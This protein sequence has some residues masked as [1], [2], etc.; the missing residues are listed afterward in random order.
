[1]C[2]VRGIANSPTTSVAVGRGLS[3]NLTTSSILTNKCIRST[4]QTNWT[5]STLPF[6][7]VWNGVAYGAGRFVA[8]CNGLYAATSVDGI[9]WTSLRM[10][11]TLNWTSITFGDGK[12]I[13]V[14][15][16]SSIA[17]FSMD[18]LNWS[19]INLPI[20]ATWTSVAYGNGRFVIPSSSVTVSLH[21]T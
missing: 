8:V 2:E 17:A 9:T 15:G 5:A 20:S 19:E 10:P 4:N 21:S 13:A 7:A 11:A 1:L 12:W 6:S 14:G 3:G 18:G 16:P